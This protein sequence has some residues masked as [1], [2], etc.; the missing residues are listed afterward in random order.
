LV[1]SAVAGETPEKLTNSIGLELLRVRAGTFLYGAPEKT[2]RPNLWHPRFQV[3]ITLTNDFH[4]GA[5][6][7][8]QAQFK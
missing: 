3:K 6:E 1:S 5:V 8:T 4:L 7:V 2:T